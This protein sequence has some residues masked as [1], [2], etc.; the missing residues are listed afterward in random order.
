VLL[1]VPLLFC[2]PRA[3]EEPSF[4]EALGWFSLGAIGLSIFAPFLV[5]RHVDAISAQ[6]T[7]LAFV[8]AFFLLA[9]GGLAGWGSTKDT[10]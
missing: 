3:D 5:M 2:R 10:Y 4:V 7:A 1:L 6:A 8:G 9:A